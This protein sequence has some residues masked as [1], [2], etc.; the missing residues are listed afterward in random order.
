MGDN[1]G[2]LAKQFES[3]VKLSCVPF[4]SR[5][6]SLDPTDLSLTMSKCIFRSAISSMSLGLNISTIVVRL[7]EVSDCL[8]RNDVFTGRSEVTKSLTCDWLS[9]GFIP[10]I[11][12]Y[13][14]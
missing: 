4:E 7:D 6:W 1:R 11:L 3:R 9:N 2:I 13:K 14:K 10:A 12:R 5:F 8:L